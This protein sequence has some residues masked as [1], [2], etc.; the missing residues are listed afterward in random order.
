MVSV[1]VAASRRPDLQSTARPGSRFGRCDVPNQ[2]MAQGQELVF[3]LIPTTPAREGQTD[4]AWRAEIGTVVRFTFESR[5][6]DWEQAWIL[7]PEIDVG[8]GGEELAGLHQREI[9]ADFFP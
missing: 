4:E 8:A 3:Q 6:K 2:R 1:Q 7:T 5:H 9:R